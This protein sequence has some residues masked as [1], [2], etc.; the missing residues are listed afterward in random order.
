[1]SDEQT[2]TDSTE[3]D[4]SD[5]ISRLTAVLESDD[6]TEEL[7]NEEEVVDEATDEVIEEDQE[8]DPEEELTEEV[9][10]DP[11]EENLDEGEET[12]ELITEGM[13]EIDGET[14]SVE[15]IKLGYL[16]QGDYTKKTQAV[17]EPHREQTFHALTM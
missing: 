3:V 13:I 10:E 9:E 2:T 8:L 15:E 14:L 11:T 7:S 17:A 16:R 12:P 6:Q 4:N 5:I 1:M